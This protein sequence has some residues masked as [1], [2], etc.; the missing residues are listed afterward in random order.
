VALQSEYGSALE[1][2]ARGT[3]R[4]IRIAPK[5]FS[6][7]ISHADPWA[8]V[9]HAMVQTKAPARRTKRYSAPRVRQRLLIVRRAHALLHQTLRELESGR[10]Q[11]GLRWAALAASSH[12]EQLDAWIGITSNRGFRI[13]NLCRTFPKLLDGGLRPW[14]TQVWIFDRQPI[15]RN[16]SSAVAPLRFV[17]TNRWQAMFGQFASSQVDALSMRGADQSRSNGWA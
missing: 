7:V 13:G 2:H 12:A 4:P 6:A 3:T 17:S 1:F 16:G 10:L 8:I 14:L 11:L 5:T 15:L 9:Q